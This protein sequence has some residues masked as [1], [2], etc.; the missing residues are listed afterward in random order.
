MRA[1]LHNTTAGRN[2]NDH[3]HDKKISNF[4]EEEF[5]GKRPL[6]NSNKAKEE[7]R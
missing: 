2:C 4:I 7:G 5:R 6:S 3:R 1:P